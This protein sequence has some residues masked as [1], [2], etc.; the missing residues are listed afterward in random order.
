MVRP[1]ALSPSFEAVLFYPS[2]SPL[3]FMSA[4]TTQHLKAALYARVS[5]EEQREGQTI[6][7]Q[8]AE[9]E[10][11]A[12]DKGWLI[13]GVYKDEGWSGS[14]LA[15]PELDRLR[16][17]ASRGLFDV[18]IIN[19]VDRL[20]RDVSHL[21][22][23]KRDLERH[24]VQVIFRKLPAE[25]SPTYNLMVNI[26]GSFAE[27]ERELIIDRT[28]RG[29]RHKVEVRKLF[30]GGNAPYGYRYVPKDRTTG[31]EGLLELIPEE[32]S[33]VRQMFEWIDK[34]GLSARRVVDRLTEMKVPPRKGGDHWGKSSVLRI[35]RTETYAGVWHYNKYEGCE[36]KSTSRSNGYKRS[37]KCS[38][39]RRDRSEWIPVVLPDSLQVVDR[40]CW[41]RVQR[42]LD[43]N[44]TFS[45]RNAKH[46]YLLKGLVKCGGCG[47]RYVGDPCHG[48]FYYR[49]LSRCKSYPTVREEV[50]NAAI[51][52]AIKEVILDPSIVADQLARLYEKRA[53]GEKQLTTEQQEVEASL[54]EIDK[55][56]E[57]VVEAYRMSILS[58]AQLGRELE[59][60]KARKASIEARKA[61]LTAN[62]NLVEL[63]ALRRS[64]EEYCKYAAGRLKSF[65]HQEKKRFLQTLISEVVFEGTRVMIR[66]FIPIIGAPSHKHSDHEPRSTAPDGGVEGMPE[67]PPG[68]NSVETPFELSQLIPQTPT[69]YEQI[70]LEWVKK[71]V[72]QNPLVTLQQLSDS[73][74][75]EFGMTLSISHMERILRLAGVSRISGSRAKQVAV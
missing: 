33:V 46:E 68:R 53:D 4:S 40:G 2:P 9:I 23:V 30:L 7:S 73:I 3:I 35:L 5:T 55:E 59:K 34:E 56:E 18:V 38:L 74:S 45:P 43:R 75:Q 41:E 17:D 31:K 10:H 19:D 27:F 48:K 47:A 50:L 22:I 62:K 20:A 15:R 58:P 63:P 6:D 39:R 51:W 71:Q 14:L 61:S 24:G 70:D 44:I 37:L 42:Q 66:G 21:G 13:L 1:L 8:V 64:L 60:L 54:A 11:F 25:K 28:R 49:C 12:K 32:A 29:R 36:P 72:R 16:D 52:K 67:H 57:R 26:L 69:I 65:D